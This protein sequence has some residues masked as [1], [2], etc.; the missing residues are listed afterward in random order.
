MSKKLPPVA[1]TFVH[2]ADIIWPINKPINGSNI[3]NKPINRPISRI[4]RNR[5]L[6]IPI[7]KQTENP[8]NPSA[9]AIKVNDNHSTTMSTVHTPLARNLI[10]FHKDMVN[11][12]DYVINYDSASFFQ[13]RVSDNCNT[14]STYNTLHSLVFSLG[15][16]IKSLL[17]HSLYANMVVNMIVG[18]L[19]D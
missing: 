19:C 5:R 2:F 18:N 6:Y 13:L 15:T 1:A 10:H 7:A 3:W 4:R 12:I 11:D 9:I 14:H 17:P 16:F 8:S